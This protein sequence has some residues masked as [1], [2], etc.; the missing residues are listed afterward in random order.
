[1]RRLRGLIGRI[2]LRRDRR[3]LASSGLF[4][5]GWYLTTY[6]DVAAAAVNACRPMP[7]GPATRRPHELSVRT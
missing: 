6:P 5:S 3:L 2:R 1:M 4:D 7:P